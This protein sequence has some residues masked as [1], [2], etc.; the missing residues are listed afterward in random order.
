MFFGLII[1]VTVDWEH[2]TLHCDDDDQRMGHYT[3]K[4]IW[5]LI[6]L[7]SSSKMQMN[8]IGARHFLCVLLAQL[9]RSIM[10]AHNAK[11]HHGARGEALCAL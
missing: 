4:A 7:L 5:L 2:Y 3:R 8:G 6:A 1:K 10:Q 9:R 11:E